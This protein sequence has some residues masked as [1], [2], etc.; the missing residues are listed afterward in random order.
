MIHTYQKMLNGTNV[1]IVFGT[2]APMHQ[3]HLDLIMRAKKECDGGCM[4]IVDGRDGDRRAIL[5]KKP[6]F[7]AQNIGSEIGS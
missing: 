5:V 1:G 7:P 2:F 6:Q 4:V 3:G